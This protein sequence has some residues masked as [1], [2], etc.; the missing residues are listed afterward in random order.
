MAATALV[1]LG[2]RLEHVLPTIEAT[3]DVG[4]RYGM[5]QIAGIPTRL[6]LAKNPASWLEALERVDDLDTP[7][8]ISVNSQVA[9]GQDP[10]WLWDVP[11]EQLRGREVIVTGERSADVAVRLRYGGVAHWV[12]PDPV[13]AIRSLTAR[14][15]DVL[16]NYTAFREL[17]AQSDHVA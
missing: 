13:Q 2:E 12:A 7:V 16:A 15:C 10:S 9:D 4:G 11:F 14:H 17:Q 6:V 1:A 5:A 3:Q 8:V